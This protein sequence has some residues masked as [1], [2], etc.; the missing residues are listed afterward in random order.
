MSESGQD[1]AWD[2]TCNSTASTR[3]GISRTCCETYC[4]SSIPAVPCPALPCPALPPSPK[5]T[6]P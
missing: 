1:A 2:S 6:L 3:C 5:H 4:S